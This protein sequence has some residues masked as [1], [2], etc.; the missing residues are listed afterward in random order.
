MK[1]LIYIL[2]ALCHVVAVQADID[3]G[4]ND[5]TL[6]LKSAMTF[7]YIPDLPSA[8]GKGC[9]QNTFDVM[10]TGFPFAIENAIVKQNDS[11]YAYLANATYTSGNSGAVV[12]LQNSGVL[13][14]V[15][16]FKVWALSVGGEDA[17]LAG[18]L[19]LQNQLDLAPDGD[20]TCALTAPLT[21]NIFL[22]GGTLFLTK[23]LMCNTGVSVSGSGTISA[24]DHEFMFGGYYYSALNSNLCWSSCN[25]IKL[26]GTIALAGAWSFEGVCCIDG[27]GATIDLRSGGSMFVRPESLLIL[28][29]V[30][31]KGITA[32]NFGFIHQDGQDDGTLQIDGAR[33]QSAADV[34]MTFG[35]LVVTGDSMFMLGDHD[36]T[37]SGDG[38]LTVD[39]A[40]LSLNV[41]SNDTAAYD[42]TIYAPLPVFSGH[43][44]NL[45][46]I[47]SNRDSGNL[48]F[49]NGG[50]VAEVSQVLVAGGYSGSASTLDESAVLSPS[51]SIDFTDHTVVDGTGSKIQFANP[52]TP[53]FTIADGKTVRI[54]NIELDGVTSSTFS[55]GTNSV[56]EIGENVIFTLAE[57]V[58]WSVGKIV[59]VG[60]GQT[61]EMKSSGPKRTWTFSS[62]PTNDH[63]PYTYLTHLDLQSNTLVLRGVA[64]GGLRHIVWGSAD[65][66][67]TTI[68]GDIALGGDGTLNVTTESIVSHNIVIQGLN[69]RILLWAYQNTFDGLISFDDTMAS[70][71]SFSFVLPTTLYGAPYIHFWD[72]TLDLSSTTGT[73]YCSFDFPSVCVTNHCVDSFVI[74]NNGILAGNLVT[75]V[76][77]SILQTSARAML[78]PGI[79]LFSELNTGAIILS[80][81]LLDAM[82]RSRFGRRYP[83]PAYKMHSRP[84]LTRG[85]YLPNE[86]ARPVVHYATA[87]S[88][89]L[90]AGNITLQ[91]IYQKVY[92]NLAISDSRSLNLTLYDGVT[93]EQALETPTTLKDTDFINIVGGTLQ[94]PNKIAITSDFTING[95]LMFGDNA[96]LC[97][98]SNSPT[99]VTITFGADS[100]ISFGLNSVLLFQGFGSIILPDGYRIVGNTS[101]FLISEGM[102]LL[103]N[104]GQAI[105]F[106]GNGVMQCQDGGQVIVERGSEIR[107]GAT[108]SDTVVLRAKNGGMVRVGEVLDI[109]DET[110]YLSFAG[111]TASLDFSQ[112]GRLII[113]QAGVCECNAYH[114]V[115]DQLM[116]DTI[117]FS[118]GG[119]LYVAG[120][121]LF[122]VADNTYGDGITL[123]LDGARLSGNGLVGVVGSSFCGKLQEN[124]FSEAGLT[125]IELVR[126]LLQANENL[127]AST[128]FFDANDQKVLRTKNGVLV[129]LNANQII[130]GD[131]EAGVV[132]GYNALTGRRF[133]YN[134]DG[135]LQ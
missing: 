97:I 90:L 12:S 95:N 41:L 54:S 128:V 76:Q 26:R 77:N 129:T 24:Q 35:S 42:R 5:A 58:L 15:N 50:V 105:E 68:V 39:A 126:L 103:L 64:L 88:L 14:G 104:E 47:A 127:I 99:P 34:V 85:L 80:D 10:F 38:S 40:T 91:D 13:N 120:D 110:S 83:T 122:N 75:I 63:A 46:N 20:L 73:A 2:V 133:S 69:N 3:F 115:A 51:D 81:E 108:S 96:V 131:T 55:L 84:L 94:K 11:T 67:G 70:G 109:G 121:G 113:T 45:E 28:R 62:A 71:L 93:V 56:L 134:A 25:S 119:E 21:N 57:D 19:V 72:G 1:K 61:F 117:D 135:V 116:I 130:T 102:Q 59:L 65:V 132:T 53:Q 18:D 114:G 37:F 124:L 101:T 49:V 107:Y 89:P 66:D 106:C 111:C 17:V 7:N 78:N 6:K 4:S 48:I 32:D 22:D 8:F 60:T 125:S 86:A 23:D 118:N 29:D 36:W 98:Q 100:I 43:V 112:G 44:K 33:L 87:I 82:L 27:D 92:N 123:L 31:I 30:A 74:G 16:G 79:Q 9:I 52:G